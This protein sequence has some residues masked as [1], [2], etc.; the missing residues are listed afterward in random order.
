MRREE[1]QKSVQNLGSLRPLSH[2]AAETSS[3][4]VQ[5]LLVIKHKQP[6]VVFMDRHPAGKPPVQ[7]FRAPAEEC[8][9]Y[10]SGDI[11]KTNTDGGKN[12]LKARKVPH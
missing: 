2:L 11:N 1:G 5:S 9:Q 7:S 8:V 6:P 4:F 12:R 3:S 10:M